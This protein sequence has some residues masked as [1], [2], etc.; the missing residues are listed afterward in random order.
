MQNVRDLIRTRKPGVN[1]SDIKSA[2][3]KLG[4]IFP[5]QYKELFKLVNNAEIGEWILFPIK[6]NSK[7]TWDDV[8]RQNIE[9]RDDRM[10]KELI[11][12]G[13]D[14]SGDKLCFKK[15]NGK[16]VDTIFLWEHDST[17]IYEYATN[18]EE[19]II[20]IFEENGEYED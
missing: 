9:V 11:A 15:M 6:T 20:R 5:V 13:D 19:F 8:V 1:E 14:G 7:K 12:I 2:E 17:K 18:L 10:S 16:M 4:V 3:E